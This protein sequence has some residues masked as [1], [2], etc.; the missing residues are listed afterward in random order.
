ISATTAIF[1]LLDTEPTVR[2]SPDATKLTSATGQID[3]ENVTFRYANTV[4]DAVSNLNLRIEP[5]KTYAL[6]GASGAG[7]STILSLILRLYDP[8]SGAVKIDGRN[9]P[10]VTQKSLRQQIGLVTQETFL[11]HDTIFKNIQF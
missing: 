11:F 6:V 9:L 5:G 4:T 1:A 3:L 7:K 2:D 8:T 10:T